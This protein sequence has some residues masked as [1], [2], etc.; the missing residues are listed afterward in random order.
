MPAACRIAT[1]A[2]LAT[3]AG[4]IQAGPA[5]APPAAA[6]VTGYAIERYTPQG[7][8]LPGGQGCQGD[9]ARFRAVMDNDYHTGNVG[10]TVYRQI[11]GEIDQADRVCAS[12][13]SGEASAMIR[14]TKSKFGYP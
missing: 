8:A 10:Q 2:A 7:F 1:L 12:G 11:T 13:N 5:P 6:P 9:V 3:L 14:T 4:C